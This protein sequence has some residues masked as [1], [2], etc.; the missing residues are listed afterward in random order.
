MPT[1]N[2]NAYFDGATINDYDKDDA[3]N[4]A[5]VRSDEGQ[6]QSSATLNFNHIGMMITQH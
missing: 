4:D 3:D 5:Y 6:S 1:T 2:N